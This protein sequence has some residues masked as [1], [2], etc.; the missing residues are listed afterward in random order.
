MIRE[1]L[2][3]DPGVCYIGDV[4]NLS[5]SPRLILLS[6]IGMLT[7]LLLWVMAVGIDRHSELP[8]SRGMINKADIGMDLFTLKQIRNGVVEWDIKADR[9]ELNQQQ[10][11]V[12]LIGMKAVLQTT[13]GLQMDFSGD[14]GLLNTGTNDFEIKENQGNLTVSMNNG[15][16]I[17]APSL[18]WKDKDR[19]IIS[20]YPIRIIGQGLWIR[21]DRMVVNLKN[22]QLIVNGDVH[23]TTA[24]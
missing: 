23:V 1:P 8:S 13:E 11:Q 12:S 5:R 6:L 2:Y 14:R 4:V 3:S 17:E 10:K 21:G 19:E 22:Q 9:A 24:P 18:T 7:L 20:E 16:I 15:Y